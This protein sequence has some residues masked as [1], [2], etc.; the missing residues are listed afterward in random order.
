LKVEVDR[1]VGRDIRVAA[2]AFVTFVK[3]V[4]NAC[5]CY[6]HHVTGALLMFYYDDMTIKMTK[7][8]LTTIPATDNPIDA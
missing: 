1:Y 7:I 6:V 4:E 5:C 8:T 3:D 2:R